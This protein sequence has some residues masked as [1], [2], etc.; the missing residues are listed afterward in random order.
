MDYQTKPTS[1]SE[2]RTIAQWFRHLMG[3]KNKYRFNVITAFEKIHQIFPQITTEIIETKSTSV[4]ANLDVPCACIPNYNG[5][6]HIVVRENIYIGA[7]RGVG[8]Y[9]AH[10]LHEISHAVLCILGFLPILERMF[11]NN[12][13]VPVFTSVEWQAKALTGEIL[14]PHQVTKGLSRK[15]IKF[16]CQ[17]SDS[18]IDFYLNL[19]K[20]DYQ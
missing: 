7:A 17:V 12:E 6:Y 3:C 14:I 19:D 20:N 10:I 13:I 2:L 5:C 1:R 4:I 8:G 18:L 9:R 15:K 11:N 16:L